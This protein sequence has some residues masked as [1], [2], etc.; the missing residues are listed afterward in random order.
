M[1]AQ[2][3]SACPHGFE[4]QL[5]TIEGSVTRGLPAFNLVG[6]A[7]KTVSE[8]RD[9]VRSALMQAGFTF[10]ARK[11]TINLAPADFHKEG[12]HLDLPISVVVLLLAKQLRPADVTGCFFAGEL[13]LDGQ[14]R[15]VRGIINLLEVARA[16]GFKRAYIPLENV[17]QASLVTGL[18]LVGVDSLTNLFRILKG[19]CDP[20][21]LQGA[22]VDLGLGSSRRRPVS[23][24][25][26]PTPGTSVSVKNTKTDTAYGFDH[27]YGQAF[28]KRALLIAI[29]GRHNILLS[30]PPGTGKTSLARAAAQ[31]LPPLTPDQSLDTTKLYSLAGVTCEVQTTCPFRTPHHSASSHAIIGSALGVPGEISLA[32]NGVLFL[33]EL[34][35]YQR[36][37]LEALRQPLE[38]QCIS[39]AGV[40]RKVTY[41]AR[42][43][44]IATMNPCPC[45]YHGDKEKPCHCTDFQIQRYQNKI[46]GPL[47]D[48]IDLSVS[49]ERLTSD[50]LQ[51]LNTSHNASKRKPRKNAVNLTNH[52]EQKICTASKTGVKSAV[53]NTC[54][55]VARDATNAPVSPSEDFAFWSQL[56]LAAE[57]IQTKRWGSGKFNGQLSS[58]TVSDQ[59]KLT[60]EASQLL[61]AATRRLQLSTR[62]YFKTIKVAQTIADLELATQFIK[63][64]SA[65]APSSGP[66]STAAVCR[67]F[68][69][70][71]LDGFPLDPPTDDAI[72]PSMVPQNL[73]RFPLDPPSV[74]IIIK[75]EHVSEALS[76]RRRDEST[77]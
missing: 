2:I 70:Q 5:I 21:P 4:G 59:V 17:K 16:H 65:S 55:D 53:K 20:C 38:D 66:R 76:F 47:L 19:E 36:D 69:P 3:F 67:H 29:A 60:P 41:P 48:R 18:E 57:R 13:A 28:A 33:D 50:E 31:L 73:D 77:A 7:N 71:N 63:Q 39:L 44:L 26:G 34:P 49:V 24:V 14:I 46:S 22:E 68:D 10:P 35:E 1:I 42:F 52:T 23:A 11:I 37:V 6:L 25:A 54:S 62:S 8:A 12:S 51:Q 72:K 58:A 64:N 15:P 75:P 56:V 45:G 9:R 43:L 32:H 40:R 61:L 74:D 27:I 30:G